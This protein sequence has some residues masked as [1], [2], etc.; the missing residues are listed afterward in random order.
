MTKA[1]RRLLVVIKELGPYR[2]T[3]SAIGWKLWADPERFYSNN[4]ARF[5]L[6]AGRFLRRAKAQ[7]LVTAWP[8]YH[9]TY[10]RVKEGVTVD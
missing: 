5:C 8:D 1:M 9:H 2:A 10:W 7:G 4:A 3:A 6:P